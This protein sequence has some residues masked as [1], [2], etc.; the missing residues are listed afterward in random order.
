MKL[1]KR[2]VALLLT[3][4]LLPT[5]SVLSSAESVNVASGKELVADNGSYI[6]DLGRAYPVEDVEISGVD[7]SSAEVIMSNDPEFP[8]AVKSEATNIALNKPILSKLYGTGGYTS[9]FAVKYAVDGNLSTQFISTPYKDSI[10]WVTVDLEKPAY[11]EDIKINFSANRTYTVIAT[12][13]KYAQGQEFDDGAEL[14]ETSRGSKEFVLPDKYKDNSYRYVR[15][16]FAGDAPS[17]YFL[18]VNMYINE[19]VVNG[20]YLDETTDIVYDTTA[21]VKK[22]STFSLNNASRDNYYRYLKVSGVSAKPSVKVNVESEFADCVNLAPDADISIADDATVLAGFGLDRVIDGDYNTFALI[23]NNPYIQFDL[24]EKQAISHVEVY[25]R[26]DMPNDR[27][28]IKILLSNAPDF[29]DYKILGEKNPNEKV[30]LKAVF[31]RGKSDIFDG[32]RY[33]RVYEAATTPIL[34][35]AEIKIFA[36]ESYKNLYDVSGNVS[37]TADTNNKVSYRATDNDIHS[38]WSGNNITVNLDRCYGVKGLSITARGD[39][40]ISYGCENGTEV[41]FDGEFTDKETKNFYFNGNVS[42]VR[43]ETTDSSA[44]RVYDVSVYSD[45]KNAYINRIVPTVVSSSTEYDVL[46][47]GRTVIIDHIEPCNISAEVSETEDFA[48][49]S[50]VTGCQPSYVAGR[51]VAVP[52]GTDA[53]VIGYDSPRLI[54]T[55][56]GKTISFDKDIYDNSTT[57]VAAIYD[58]NKNLESVV[59]GAVEDGNLTLNNGDKATF[60]VWESI[61]SMNPLLPKAETV[62]INKVPQAEFYVDPDVKTSGDGT[63]EKPFKTIPEAKN[64]VRAINSKMTGDIIVNLNGGRY[65]L[66]SALTF[67]TSDGGTNGYNVIYKNADSEMPVITGGRAITGFSEWENGIWCAEAKDFDSIYELIV[68]GET[69]QIAKTETAINAVAFYSNGISFSKSKLPLITNA[70]EA[71]VHVTRSWMDV[72][73][74]VTAA[75]E[76]G[77]II[78]LDIQQPRFNEVTADG[79]LSGHK[80]VPDSDFYIENALELLDNPGEFYFD[81]S[82]K[83]LYYMPREGE[84]MNTA[85]VEAAVLERLVKISGT[86]KSNHIEN[87]TFSGI[88]FENSTFGKMYEYGLKTAQ[89][90]IV[91]FDKGIFVDGAIQIDYATNIGI[92]DCV[93]TGLTKPAISMGNGVVDTVISRNRIYNVGDSAVVVGNN[94][95]YVISGTKELCERVTISYNVINRSGL[96]HKGAPG[97]TCYYVTD[98]NILHN[99]ITECNYSGISL[100]WGWDD[101]PDSTTCKRNRVA[102]NYIENVNLTATDGGAIY[103]LGNQPGTVIEDNYIVQYTAPMETTGICGIYPDEGSAYITIRN[104]VIDMADIKDYGGAVRDLNLW[105]STVIDNHAHDNYT[106]YTNVRNDGTNCLV[107]APYVYVRGNEP[108]AAKRVIGLSAEKLQ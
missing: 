66:D 59:S 33:V 61:N 89:A 72:L 10:E 18:D 45:D 51:Y 69:A 34:V 100:G 42:M 98:T 107:D 88:R 50:I 55:Q 87:L 4:A 78:N 3:A 67:N 27:D 93:I 20:S 81:K 101:Y 105:T 41:S 39:I 56:E 43:L 7:I 96:K 47:L 15:L 53:S 23:G 16:R 75:N 22:G 5:F 64:A 31:A 13:T 57:A 106:T 21:L 95:Q 86:G 104:N 37:Q 68:N 91:T 92:S 19:L 60:M 26:Q 11:I 30:G 103:T 73:L 2:A 9:E 76:N 84:D 32:Y 35:L 97:I 40:K 90:Q 1:L 65:N 8:Q 99:K 62:Y 77:K 94:S 85:T 46:D 102:E 54:N 6:L 71:F 74:K 38:F 24:K 83:V 70:E 58:D 82:E 52:A 44:I 25:C 29:Y 80:V 28:N 63:K 14:V 48:V 108:A 12:N 17:D 36:N 79:A 49:S